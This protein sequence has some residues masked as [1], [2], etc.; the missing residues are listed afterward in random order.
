ME[1]LIKVL[2]CKVKKSP[3]VENIECNFDTYQKIVGGYIQTIR[4]DANTILVCN[5]DGKILNLPFNRPLFNNEGKVVDYIHG[6]FFIVG[7]DGIEDF[8]D[9]TKEQINFW[10]RRFY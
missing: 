2:I 4:L 8:T 9:L 7:F 1:K 10:G 6:D 5:D 3:Y